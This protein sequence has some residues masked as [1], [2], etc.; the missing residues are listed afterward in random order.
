[1]F[2]THCWPP[3]YFE[4]A[5][6]LTTDLKETKVYHFHEKLHTFLVD[7]QQKLIFVLASGAEIEKRVRASAKAKSD[8]EKCVNLFNAGNGRVIDDI[9]E[10]AE[11]IKDRDYE[12]IHY[13]NFGVKCVPDVLILK[14]PQILDAGEKLD[15]VIEANAKAE[16][17]AMER[18]KETATGK[19]EK[20]P[21]EQ[22]ALALA[23]NLMKEK[24]W[25]NK[26]VC[27]DAEKLA[28]GIPTKPQRFAEKPDGETSQQETIE[29]AKR[30]LI[31]PTLDGSLEGELTERALINNLKAYFEKKGYSVIILINPI[32]YKLDGNFGKSKKLGEK[33]LPHERDVILICKGFNVILNIEAK[34]T[35][36]SGSGKKACSQLE[37]SRDYIKANFE[38]TSGSQ[39]E[40]WKFVGMVYADKFVDAEQFECDHC[41]QFV[42]DENNLEDCLDNI[43]KEPPKGRIISK[44]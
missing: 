36:N 30:A 7:E 26:P 40:E 20:N 16:K 29:D 42:L 12:W 15:Q 32:I 27:D 2:L 14:A 19:K 17:E 9:C 37:I 25:M 6:A 44:V 1:M 31:K 22:R 23:L 18:E 34:A 39:T 8:K 33:D 21:E 28:H 24:F 43:F 4:M 41:K 5:E 3:S 13:E 35:L 11:F 38:D 10:N